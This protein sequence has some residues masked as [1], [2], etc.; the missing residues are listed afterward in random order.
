MVEI[1]PSERS[2]YVLT[3]SRRPHS[4]SYANQREYVYN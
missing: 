3:A 2:L 4:E 1:N